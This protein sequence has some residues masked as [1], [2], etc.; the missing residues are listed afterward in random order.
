MTKIVQANATQTRFGQHWEEVPMEQIVGIQ[1]LALRR[2]ED[3]VVQDTVPAASECG[4]EALIS[5]FEKHSA[6]LF[7]HVDPATFPV[8][9]RGE[10]TMDVVSLHQD[11]SIWIVFARSELNVTPLQRH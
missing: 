9:R 4:E 8:L 11:E 2:G 10:L 1:D 7:R 3:E 6:Q 5:Q